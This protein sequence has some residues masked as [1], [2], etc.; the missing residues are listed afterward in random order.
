MIRVCDQGG[1]M[2][3][4]AGRIGA[5]LFD[6]DG[7]LIDSEVSSIDCLISELARHGI[8][9]DRTYVMR[10][11]MGRS[12]D[13]VTRHAREVF[14]RPLPDSAEE[15]YRLAV[16]RAFAAAPRTMPGLPLLLRRLALPWAV[17]TSS[18]R[19]RVQATLGAAGLWPLARPRLFTTEMVARSK[20]A[21]DLFLL[22]A[23]RLG[24]PPARCVVIEDS[25]PGLQA[26]RAAGVRIPA[27][28]ES[29]LCGTCKIMKISG[30]VEMEH[31]GG[32]LDE[33]IEEGY[34]LACCS[35]PLGKL[36][37]EA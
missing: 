1:G 33:E 4:Q 31:N 16:V 5:V 13:T 35:K 28:C 29:G 24:V 10:H 25:L 36:E 17:V 6:C 26:A 8:A 34:I 2:R 27:A 9:T 19:A 37:V 23:E 7:V 3:H 21:P 22:A 18:T 20:P 32:I 11:F 12:F 15:D 30:Q 14:A